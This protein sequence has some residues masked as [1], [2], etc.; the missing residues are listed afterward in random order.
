MSEKTAKFFLEI[1]FNFNI[2]EYL[3]LVEKWG[4]LKAEI[5]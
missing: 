3:F 2:I 4:T 5:R 1:F